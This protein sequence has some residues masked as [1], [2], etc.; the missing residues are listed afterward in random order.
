M[1]TALRARGKVRR[2]LGMQ[3]YHTDGCGLGRWEDRSISIWYRGYE[4]V[5]E[6]LVTTWRECRDPSDVRVRMSRGSASGHSP[7]SAVMLDSTNLSRLEASMSWVFSIYKHLYFS[8]SNAAAAAVL[9][10]L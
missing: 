3:L 5:D 7:A 10:W 9:A 8:S 6:C 1:R 4:V 2:G